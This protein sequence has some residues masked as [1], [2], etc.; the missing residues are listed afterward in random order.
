MFDDALKA[1]RNRSGFVA[2]MDD[3]NAGNND[4]AQFDILITRNTANIAGVLPF[5]IFGAAALASGLQNDLANYLP[6][7]ST[8]LI[9]LQY[10]D[11]YMDVTGEVPT[12][13][14]NLSEA[15][16]LRLEYKN[17]ANKDVVEI[18][19][20]TIAYP[21]FVNSTVSD[22]F[23][24]SKIRMSLSDSTQSAQ[25]SQSIKYARRTIF[26]KKTENSFAP[27]AFRTPDQ[28]QSGIVD[29]LVGAGVDKETALWGN[30]LGV[31][32]FTITLSL[33]VSKVSKFNVNSQL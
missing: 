16:K 32:G 25:F 18:T 27:S 24:L 22:V 23:E 26:G 4:V 14:P 2:H 31:A 10:G 13:V 7:A 20:N 30:I 11:I 28:F 1:A 21:E 8:S 3:V 6:N 19:C 15:K 9:A 5:P 29:I 17:G 12:I 33:F